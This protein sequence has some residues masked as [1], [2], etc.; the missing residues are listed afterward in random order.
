MRT[1]LC[2]LAFA[3][4]AALADTV[5]LQNGKTLEGRVT[6]DGDS[7]TIEF[8]QGKVKINKA[9]V[10]S[11]TPKETPLDEAA[12][13]AI[14][15]QKQ[16]TEHKLEKAAEA[17]LWYELAGWAGEK[18][19]PR[20]RADALKMVL[21]LEPDHAG[22]RKDSGYVLHNGAWMTPAERN[23]A[24]GLVKVDGRWTSPEAL[25]DLSRAR[26]AAANSGDARPTKADDPHPT[27]PRAATET[28]E[29]ERAVDLRLKEAQARK[30]EAEAALLEAQRGERGREAWEADRAPRSVY[31][32][33]IRYGGVY[34]TDFI[35]FPAV[36]GFPQY[37][38]PAPIQ[39]K[40]APAAPSSP[41]PFV[42][43][44]TGRQDN[45]TSA[46]NN[47]KSGPGYPVLP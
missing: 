18:Q 22:A 42:L 3:A 17:M 40:T 15:I 34:Y 29:Q 28:D 10:K 14:D 35:T 7:V 19:L 23:Q 44:R 25:H 6:T 21:A 37:R 13:R 39:R 45:W 24:L 33:V 20:A 12:R 43:R 36:P 1:I 30:L 5:V 26:E 41:A 27:K 2:L 38:I 16:A 11:I 47:G 8:A 31:D 4:P 32:P 46:L 9:L